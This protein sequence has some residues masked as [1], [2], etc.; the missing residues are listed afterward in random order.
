MKTK[1]IYIIRHGQTDF[2]KK[3][4]VQGRGVDSSLNELGRFQAAQ[5]HAVYK[6]IKFD[7]IY[8]STLK[9]TIESVALFLAD[10][11]ASE[12]LPGLDEIS[13]GSHEGQPYDQLRHGKYLDGLEQW[14]KGNIDYRVG[15]GETPLEVAERQKQA[16]EY[17]LSK[18]EEETILIAMHGRAMRIMLC[19][20]ENRPLKEADRYEHSNLCLYHLT[21]DGRQFEI[22]KANESSHIQ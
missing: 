20:M 10:G 18:P 17:L 6:K 4:M 22:I 16:I 8:T 7:K 5:F 14:K 3:N 21:H 15:G 12:P 9:R 19:W 2:N 1:N 11:I 13:W